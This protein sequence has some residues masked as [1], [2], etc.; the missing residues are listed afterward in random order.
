[1][2]T[3]AQYKILIIEDDAPIR[4]MYELKLKNSG[5]LV[6]SAHDGDVGLVNAKTF[7]PDLILLDLRLP[8]INGDVMLEKLRQTDWGANIRVVILTNI[9][10]DE[11]PQSLRVL[12]VDRYIVKAHHTP[13]QIVDIVRDILAIKH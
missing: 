4:T 1:M 3:E 8:T 9:S 13:A 2:S 10:K 7:M 12:G 6:Q 5:F 11:A